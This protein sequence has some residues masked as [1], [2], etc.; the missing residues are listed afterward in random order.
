MKLLN[1]IE[2]K[3][4]EFRR[5]LEHFLNNNVISFTDENNVTITDICKEIRYSLK[6]LG[7][8]QDQNISEDQ[9]PFDTIEIGVEDDFYLHTVEDEIIVY[10]NIN[11]NTFREMKKFK[12]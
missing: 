9:F 11:H 6:Y 10:L 2:Q 1:T 3:E 4:K 8:H 12:L 5:I 7:G